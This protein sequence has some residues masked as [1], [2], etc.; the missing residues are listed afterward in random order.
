[1]PAGVPS[2]GIQKPKYRSVPETAENIQP[3][4]WSVSNILNK[5]LNIHCDIAFEAP[6][7]R[8]FPV[9]FFFTKGKITMLSTKN[10][11]SKNPIPQTLI[12]AMYRYYEDP[13]NQ[14]TIGELYLLLK[15]IVSNLE[16]ELEQNGM[17]DDVSQL[18]LA[19]LT[20]D[21]GH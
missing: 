3:V 17:L 16:D 6:T 10:I 21:T 13:K 2:V 1:M 15:L 7:T 18:P 11:L 14:M 12:T 20:A 19:P 8:N 4:G 5:A 9:V